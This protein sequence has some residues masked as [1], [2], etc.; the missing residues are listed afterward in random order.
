[1]Q[2]CRTKLQ[3]KDC[4]CAPFCKKIKRNA[5]LFFNRLEYDCATIHF[6][7]ISNSMAAAFDFV[8]YIATLS[9][10]VPYVIASV[11]QLKLVWTGET[12][13]TMQER[14]TDGTIAVLAT[15]YS[16]WLVKAGTAD[17][18]TFLLGI[19]L[20]AS[21]LLFIHLL[22]NNKTAKRTNKNSQHNKSPVI[23]AGTH[24]LIFSS[25]FFVFFLAFSNI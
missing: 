25:L 13:R 17:M 2:K 23:S 16:I 11:F 12:Y 9:Y 10:L 7:T 8:I 15:I 22:L 4:L 19:A 5:A 24:L 3:N 20:L 6:S 18:K 21:S 14:M 1:M